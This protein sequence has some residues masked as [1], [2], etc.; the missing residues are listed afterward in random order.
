[1]YFPKDINE[2]KSIL[3]DLQRYAELEGM[4]RLSE[5]LA[6]ARFEISRA[7]CEMNAIA[8]QS[9]DGAGGRVPLSVSPPP[10]SGKPA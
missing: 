4:L 10:G 8:G 5:S 9:S 6:D 1:M 2:L 3:E 7:D